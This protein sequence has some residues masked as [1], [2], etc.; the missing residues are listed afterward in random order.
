MDP[1]PGCYGRAWPASEKGRGE[2]E[3]NPAGSK[4]G[5]L[6]ESDPHASVQAFRSR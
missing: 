3:N 6:L 4:E 5:R 1:S 2:F